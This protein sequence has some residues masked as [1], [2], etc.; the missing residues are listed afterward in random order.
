LYILILCQTVIFAKHHSNSSNS[1]SWKNPREKEQDKGYLLLG[2]FCHS[3]GCR[4]IAN[5]QLQ[6]N[7]SPHRI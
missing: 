7:L 5:Y 2:P 4:P 6:S 1:P 3:A